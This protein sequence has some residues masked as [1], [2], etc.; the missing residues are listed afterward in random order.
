M[1]LRRKQTCRFSERQQNSPSHTGNETDPGER[2]REEATDRLS[3]GTGPQE[4]RLSTPSA[5]TGEETIREDRPT[6]AVRP[7]TCVPPQMDR[8]KI[9]SDLHRGTDLLPFLRGTDTGSPPTPQPQT[10][11]LCHLT[12]LVLVLAAFHPLPLLISSHT[13]QGHPQALGP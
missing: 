3:R 10:R 7:P 13:S 12:T 9:L 5:G 1:T 6:D 11:V 8:H 4:G 2:E